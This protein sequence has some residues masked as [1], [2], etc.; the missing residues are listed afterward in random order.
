MSSSSFFSSRGS[1]IGA[2]LVGVF[3]EDVK[4]QV[5]YAVAAVYFVAANAGFALLGA[6]LL[7]QE[8]GWM[9]LARLSVLA[10]VVG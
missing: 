8:S 3:P 10:G 5:H 4:P 6:R 1:G 2:L 9:R 7:A